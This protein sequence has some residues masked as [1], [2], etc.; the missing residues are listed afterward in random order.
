MLKP[1]KVKE[2]FRQQAEA[3][4]ITSQELVDSI[5]ELDPQVGDMD[6]VPDFDGIEDDIEDQD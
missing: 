4:G 1:K 2:W 3:K 6:V 5:R